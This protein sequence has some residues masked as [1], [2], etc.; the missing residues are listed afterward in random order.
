MSFSC[1]TTSIKQALFIWRLDAW[2]RY[3]ILVLFRSFS[4]PSYTIRWQSSKILSFLAYVWRKRSIL[5]TKGDILAYAVS[6]SDIPTG[7]LLLTAGNIF[8]TCI[9]LQNVSVY[10]TEL[11]FERTMWVQTVLRSQPTVCVRW[12]WR[13]RK[14][15]RRQKEI[16][17]TGSSVHRPD[18]YAILMSPNKGSETAVHSAATA[19]VT[20]LWASVRNWPIPRSWY[21]CFSA[22]GIVRPIPS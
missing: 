16:W 21:V 14:C 19:G 6:G 18:G 15:K 5:S 11:T 8:S 13:L 9:V 7:S 2:A 12:S 1:V 17:H 20:W 3:L 10:W 22:L 4:L